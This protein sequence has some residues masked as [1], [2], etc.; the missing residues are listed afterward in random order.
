MAIVQISKIQQRSGNL[1]DLPQ[2]DEAEFGFAADEKRLFI[3][4]TSENIENIEVLTSY[5]NIDFSQIN[6]AVG[7][8]DIT[9]SSVANGQVLTYDGNNW[10]NRGGDAGGLITLGD[11][12][13]VKI[14]GGAIGYVLETDGT[15]N[16]SWTAKSS[17]LSFIEN[18]YPQALDLN[19]TFATATDNATDLITLADITG[20]EVNT[21]VVFS[22]TAFGNISTGTNYYVTSV[23]LGLIAISI[24][25]S[26]GGANLTL[27]TDTGNLTVNIVGTVVKTTEDNIFTNGL[28]ATI[29]N[30]QGMVE[31]NGGSYYL[32][33]LSANTLALYNDP[34]FASSVDSTTLTPYSYTSVTAT[35]GSTNIVTVGDSNSFAQF[36]PVIFIGTTF[37]NITANQTYYIANIVSATE[38]K[39][40]TSDDGNTS[41]VV[42]LTT[43]SGTANVYVPGGRII[44]TIGGSGGVANAGGAQYSVQYNNTNLLD[45][46]ANFT[47]NFNTKLLTLSGGNANVGNLNATG[48]VT[49]TQIFSNIANGTPPLQVVSTDRVSNL[50]VAYSNVADFSVVTAQTT[51]TFY[52]TF[53][54]TSTT[55]N[56]A[57]GVNNAFSFNA[58][59]GNLNTTL[60]HTTGLTVNG[61][62][63]S[64]AS[65]VIASTN[66]D[67]SVVTG[68]AAGQIN[69][70]VTSF[71]APGIVIGSSA[72]QHGAVVY[73]ANTMYFGTENGSD[74]SMTTKASLDSNG[75]F[76][77]TSVTITGNIL[78]GNVYANSGTVGASLLT[79]TLT[80]AAQPNITSLGTL[81]GLGVNGTITGVNITA[82]TGVFSGNGSG[83]TALTGA[84][85]TG[86]VP[87]ATTAGTVTTAAQP[88]I[89]SVGTLTSL[90]VSGATSITGNSALTTTNIT[91]GAN[92]T[93]GYLTGNWTLTT[94]SRLQ[95]T[96]A[97]IAENYL[98][99]AN[100]APGT[101]LMFGGSAEL[102]L[103]DD[104]TTKVAGVVS[105][106]PSFIM[107]SVLQGQNVVNLALLGRVPVKI[108]G[109]VTRGDLIVSAGNGYAKAMENPSVGT[110]IG[111][112]IVDFNIQVAVNDLGK[113]VNQ[114]PSFTYNGPPDELEAFLVAEATKSGEVEG[115]TE[116]LVGI[117]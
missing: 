109:N 44:S 36:D 72:G 37:G 85:V 77:T 101:V 57:L 42:I 27:T 14:T 66:I 89:T 80:T 86:T 88:N 82:N 6:G 107:N 74:N 7:N 117:G 112:A 100:Y 54:S 41:N 67:P 50:N 105:T 31:L 32:D 73:A 4:K 34:L 110:V 1:V 25:D 8:L 87:L 48:I 45:G 16:L 26:Q 2:L 13:N 65:F 62:A 69:E 10:V 84:N 92:T 23:D 17:L 70:T 61:N 39:I 30:A 102:T 81:T 49:A 116:I 90:T 95:S 71:N 96:Y 93:A 98:A 40:S 58:L 43:D 33:I 3:G 64:Y 79:G 78:A 12:S 29:T 115:I 28:T 19:S 15:G 46:D 51:G 113:L 38:I 9:A 108:R 99:D 53:V 21:C 47:Y 20:Y 76:S 83:L 97:D 11:A 68:F 75:L 52:P 24:S 103:A 22:G 18:I 104:E 106:E 5:S 91:T 35:T 55:G 111:K 56:K 60:L 114:T 94:G 59:T 63:N